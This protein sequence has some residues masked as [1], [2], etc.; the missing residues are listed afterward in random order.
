MRIFFL[1]NNIHIHD[2]AHTALYVPILAVRQDL[3][4]ERDVPAFSTA[5]CAEPECC[6]A[7]DTCDEDECVAR[8]TNAPLFVDCRGIHADDDCRDIC[9]A[10]PSVPPFPFG[11]SA[12]GVASSV[13]EL[14][15]PT[16]PGL[17]SVREEWLD[18]PLFR[19]GLLA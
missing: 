8:T 5:T 18:D 9:S 10:L 16:D 13:L 2:E 12:N 3:V 19:W 15:M 4:G 7:R 1:L 11:E 6:D 17:D 14:F